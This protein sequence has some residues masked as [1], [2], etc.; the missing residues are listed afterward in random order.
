MFLMIDCR[1]PMYFDLI[2]KYEKYISGFKIYNYMG[3]FPYDIRYVS[4]K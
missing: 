1:R 2:K 4:S 3:T